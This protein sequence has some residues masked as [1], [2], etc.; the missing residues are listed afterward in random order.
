MHDA[1]L[2]RERIARDTLRR[3]LSG[4]DAE[5]DAAKDAVASSARDLSILGDDVTKRAL[6]A[7]RASVHRLDRLLVS[8]LHIEMALSAKKNVV[9]K[10]RRKPR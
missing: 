2:E 10:M 7:V 4:L 1:E 3:G 9:R 8:R 5:V 6:S